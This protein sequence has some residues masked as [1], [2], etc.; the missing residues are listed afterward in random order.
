VQSQSPVLQYSL[1]AHG[2]R[3]SPFT[4]SPYTSDASRV[5]SFLV[6]A[7]RS[8]GGGL[9]NEIRF[10]NFHVVTEDLAIRFPISSP[11]SLRDDPG[12]C[13]LAPRTNLLFGISVIDALD[14]CDLLP[15]ARSLQA[16]R[17]TESLVGILR[18]K[19]PLRR[20]SL[21]RSVTIT[22]AAPNFCCGTPFL[23]VPISLKMILLSHAT[24]A[25][26]YT[27]LQT[28]NL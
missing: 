28:T 14:L 24:A 5:S 4:G 16:P 26:R 9:L 23:W 11:I 1:L 25:R 2:G 17:S 18:A 27:F 21:A 10:H 13:P 3:S 20:A 12:G 7:Y 8:R 19:V 22:P 6:K 15:N